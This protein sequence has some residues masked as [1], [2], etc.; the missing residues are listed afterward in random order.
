[1]RGRICVLFNYVERRKR[2]DVDEDVVVWFGSRRKNERKDTA[3][4]EGEKKEKGG[5]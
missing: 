2:R 5:E 1:M 4:M 3:A